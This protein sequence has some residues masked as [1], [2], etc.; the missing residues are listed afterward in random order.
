MFITDEPPIMR[1]LQN[2]VVGMLLS[3]GQPLPFEAYLVAREPKVDCYK[4]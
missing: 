2:L 4:D 3:R 1:R